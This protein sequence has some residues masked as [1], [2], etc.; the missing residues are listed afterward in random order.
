MTSI[1]CMF[2]E[3]ETGHLHSS[4]ASIISASVKVPKVKSDYICQ[5]EVVR[6][7]FLEYL[8]RCAI[9]KYFESGKCESEL[10][11]VTMFIKNHVT[12]YITD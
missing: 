8:L 10:E 1:L 3:E 5:N 7:Q 4:K 12:K 6:F 11:A 2:E 9:K